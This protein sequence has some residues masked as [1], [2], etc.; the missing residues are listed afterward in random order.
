MALIKKIDVENHFAARRAMRL[1]RI[2]LMSQPVA[3]GT[4]PAAKRKRVPISAEAPNLGHSSPSVSSA[5]IPITTDSGR[6][7]LLR[8]PGSGQE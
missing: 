5:S 7:R 2:G 1:G 4:E 8:P 3:A 6:N